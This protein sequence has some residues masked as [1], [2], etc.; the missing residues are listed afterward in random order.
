MSPLRDACIAGVTER[1]KQLLDGDGGAHVDEKDEYGKTAL[2]WASEFGHTEVVRLLLEKGALLD[3][4]DERRG[5]TALMQ[6]SYKG[7]TEVV[8]LLLDKGALVDEKDEGGYTALMRANANGH[9]EVVRLLLDKGALRDEKNMF[10]TT[11]LMQASG[12]GDTEVV[13]LLLD[14]GALLDE[15]DEYGKTAL[16][17][18]SLNGHT[19]VVRLLLDKGALLDEKDVNGRTALMKASL[20]GHTEVVRLLFDKGALLDAVDARGDGALLALAGVDEDHLGRMAAAQTCR[21]LLQRGDESGVPALE[22]LATAEAT[23]TAVLDLVRLAGFAAARARTLRS[24]DPR[25]ADDHLVLFGRLQ[26]AAAACVQNDESGKARGEK[27]V[28]KLFCSGDGRTALEHAVQIQAKELLAQPV[29]KRYVELAWHGDPDILAQYLP[30]HVRATDLRYNSG[31]A[32][33]VARWTLLT[34]CLLLNLLF[35]LPLVALVPALEPWLTKQLLDNPYRDN[36]NAYLLRLP[37]V[38]FGLECAADLAL[39]LALTLL[40]AADL[41]TAPVA[42]LMLIWVGS[43]LLWEARQV[44]AASSSDAMS[45][46]ARVYDRL[47]AYWADSINRVD[48]MA[49]IFSFA[50]LIAFVSTDDSEDATATSLRSVAVFLL[51]LRVIRVLLI[52]PKFGPFVMMFFLML[53]GDVLYFLVLLIFL[54]VAFAASWTVLLEPQ[55]SIAGCADELGGVDFHTTLL[56]L[57]EGAL[58]GNDFF[59]CARDSTSSPVAAWVITSVYVTLTAVLLLNML[60]AMCA[61]ATHIPHTEHDPIAYSTDLSI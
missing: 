14:K 10:G 33:M 32:R 15:K 20:N 44:I 35:L 29:V 24:S 30:L 3:E 50:A 40:P 49:L 48:A 26:L 25:S 7:H 41:A 18:A 59:E 19:E 55:S 27:A 56:R 51:W 23:A 16:M 57:L 46:L 47:A 21:H 34:A 37:V 1:V 28:H 4:K 9:T 22:K 6:A 5:W 61:D 2:M 36:S 17:K 45:R 39:A 12:N 31:L 43:G 52:S 13:R 60:I 53:F 38:K 11:A 42:P 54:L 8:R 58:T